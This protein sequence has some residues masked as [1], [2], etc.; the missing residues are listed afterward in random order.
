[1]VCAVLECSDKIDFNVSDQLGRSVFLAACNWNEYLPGYRH[2]HW[3]SKET[4]PAPKILDYG[5]DP[6]AVDNEGRNALHHLLDNPDMEE[7]A[8][9]Q[10]LSNDASKV[11]LKQK[12]GKGFSPL[13]CALR[14]LSPLVCATPGDES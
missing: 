1:M 9:L 14:I 4:A 6:L 11:L 7:D 5:A 13:H 3:V 12:D 10:F 2:R 8:I